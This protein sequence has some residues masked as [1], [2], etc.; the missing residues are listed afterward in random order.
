[1]NNSAIPSRLTVVFSAS[2]DKNTIPVNSTSETLADGLAAMDSGFPPLT[3]IA[4]SA[5]GKPPK[6][7]DFNGIFNDLYTRLQ[8]SDA[9]MGYPFNADFRTAISGYPKGAVI[10]SSDYSVSWLNT[11][12][13]NNTAPEKTDATASGWMPSWGC[14]AASISISTA[15]VNATDLQAA[16]PRLILTGALTG[17]RILYLPPWVKDWTIENNCTGSAYYVQL[18]SR[19]A[20]AT[21]VSKPGTVTQIHSDGT[22]VTSLSK[23]HGN[24]AYAVNGTYSFV[25]PAGV[26]RIRYTVTGAGGSGSGCQASSSSESYSGG[27]GGAGGTALG[28]LDVVPGT[29]LSVVVGKGGAAVLGAVSGNDGGDSSLGGI[30]FGRGGKK[31]NKASI[32]NSAGGDGGVA[33]GGDINIQGGTGHDGQAATNMLTGSGGAS[34]WGGGGRSG[35]TGGVKGKA[36]GSG[37]G[38]AYDIDFSGIAYPSGDG[39]DG[40]VHIEW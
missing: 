36:A 24:I 7:Q 29:T 5:G 34:F 28:W 22:N 25:V 30:I 20:G 31:S 33:S 39:A 38:G 37:G 15:N 26:T 12:D 32:V 9:G 1:M 35:A 4:L 21:V 17:N 10:P 16:N 18:S 11:I 23:P 3:R 13:S 14:G 6:G 19:A 27:G 2:G 40:I 8:W